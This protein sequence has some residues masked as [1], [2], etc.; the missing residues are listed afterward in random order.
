M[1]FVVVSGRLGAMCP[2]SIGREQPTTAHHTSPVAHRTGRQGCSISAA[3]K[4]TTARVR[5]NCTHPPHHIASN[6]AQVLGL[7][8]PCPLARANSTGISLD[9]SPR[10]AHKWETGWW[11][12]RRRGGY[13]W[14]VEA[15]WL[16]V[17]GGCGARLGR[18]SL[19]A[20]GG[21]KASW[22]TVPSR[23][24]EQILNT[25]LLKRGGI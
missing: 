8:R 21:S 4:R 20:T 3:I 13:T 11:K 12:A 15:G 9:F 6:S 2:C 5:Q 10:P 19:A 17:E 14:L 18:D 16:W 1:E 25:F 7:T 22:G 24:D 23:R